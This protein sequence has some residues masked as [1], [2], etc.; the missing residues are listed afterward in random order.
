V[1]G[2]V[3]PCGNVSL[4]A[5]FKTPFGSIHVPGEKGL[6]KEVGGTD[7]AFQSYTVYI[8]GGF[9]GLYT[10]WTAASRSRRQALV[11]KIK[12][13]LAGD[14][15]E[16][17][18]HMTE[19]EKKK[20][21]EEK[22][23]PASEHFVAPCEIYRFMA[24]MHPG[25]VGYP[26]YGSNAFQ[27]GICAYMQVYLPVNI[28]LS[29]LV[30]WDFYG[31][32]SPFW[33][34]FN[35]VAFATKIAALGNVVSLFVSKNTVML[36]Q[37]AEAA[38]FLVT[39]DEPEPEKQT[40]A[41]GALSSVLGSVTSFAE[42]AEKGV[43]A[44]RKENPV[45]SVAS[46]AEPLLDKAEKGVEAAKENPEATVE[47]AKENPEATV[48]GAKEN[49]AAT[50]VAAKG[51]PTAAV[52]AGKEE[53]EAAVGAAKEKAEAA[54]AA[55]EAGTEKAE[56]AEAAVEAGKEKAEAAVKAAKEKAEAAE[57]AAEAAKEKVEAA[58]AEAE[59]EAAALANGDFS[60]VASL[61]PQ[62]PGWIINL[63]EKFWLI[64]GMVVNIIMS[65]GLVA[66]MYI[67]VATFSGD[68]ADIAI[69][70]VALYFVSDLDKKVLE[71]N[72]KMQKLYGKKV[73]EHTV[74]NDQK[75]VWIKKAIGVAVHGLELSIPVGIA[76]I[77]LFAW[78]GLDGRGQD[79]VIGGDPFSAVKSL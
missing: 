70:T 9:A 27:A 74:V 22:H 59:R 36:K 7:K 33:W 47:A 28:F 30:K 43:E 26:E 15:H 31:I 78:K 19:E 45:G 35:I 49:P 50:V 29:T 14:L 1:L 64:V 71:A 2:L 38:W 16:E 69:V 10:L 32:K 67:K 39:H 60:A 8:V 53:A 65:Y 21:E 79:I 3:K 11:A 72:P 48:E 42:Q 37:T 41:S 52:E 40:D 77:C 63:N 57:A 4:P 61:I 13:T 73:L 5:D 76:F 20:E 12:R 54:E 17:D 56:A 58:T 25:V 51:N 18:P 46:L 75:P 55:V 62:P 66:C 68:M 44:A 6:E 34:V 23:D 24:V